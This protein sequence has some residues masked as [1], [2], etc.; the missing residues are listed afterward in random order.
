MNDFEHVGSMWSAM[1]ILMRGVIDT[2]HQW[3]AVSLTPPVS[4]ELL[5]K[6]FDKIVWSAVSLTPPVSGQRCH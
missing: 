4:A 2:I 6:M 3:S 1:S 5:A